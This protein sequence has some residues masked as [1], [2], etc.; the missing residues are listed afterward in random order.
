MLNAH[1]G[2]QL[3]TLL[4]GDGGQEP[5]EVDSVLINSRGLYDFLRAK[6]LL[7]RKQGLVHQREPIV[8]P[9]ITVGCAAVKGC[10]CRAYPD[11]H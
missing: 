7:P 4:A 10:T 9:R 11:W 8:R 2:Q 6:G 5:I 1:V 3:P